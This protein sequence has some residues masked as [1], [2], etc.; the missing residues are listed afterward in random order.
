MVE[1]LFWQQD[2]V[3][4]VGVRCIGGMGVGVRGL[5]V[6]RWSISSVCLAPGSISNNRELESGISR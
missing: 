3:V 2:E 1:W 4:V 6:V 5:V